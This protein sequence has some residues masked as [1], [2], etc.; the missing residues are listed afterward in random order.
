MSKVIALFKNKSVTTAI[1]YCL[2]AAGDLTGNHCH[3]YMRLVLT[4][5]KSRSRR[6]AHSP[7]GTKVRGSRLQNTA[8]QSLKTSAAGVLNAE[9]RF[10]A[11]DPLFK[12][13]GLI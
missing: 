5:D 2:V 9:R 4:Q 10:P 1:E 11:A 12:P 6:S 8:L 7:F 13:Q 3:W